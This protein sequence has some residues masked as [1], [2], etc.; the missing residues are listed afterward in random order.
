MA[1]VGLALMLLVGAGLLGRSF[2]QLAT[3]DIG[4]DIDQ[5]LEVRVAARGARYQEPATLIDFSNRLVDRLEQLPGVEAAGI[6]GP[7]LP[8]S[9]NKSGMHFRRDDLPNP[10]VGEEPTADIRLVAGDYFEAAGIELQQGRYLSPSDA[11]VE[12][13]RVVVNEALARRYFGG[14][15]PVGKRITFEWYDTLRAEIVGVVGNV[16][17]MGPAAAPSP[18]IYIPFG[19][20][21]DDLFHVMVRTAGE[22]GAVIGG[23][24]AAA[25]SVDPNQPFTVRP[26]TDVA[27]E[28][29]ARPTLNL[30]L[31]G[32]FSAIAMVLAAI[33]LY[34]V[35]SYTVRQRRQ[36]IGVRVALGAERWDVVRLVLGQG[37]RLTAL[38]ILLGLIGSV[39][40]TRLM[41]SMLFG[42]E[43]MDELTLL[44]V[45]LFLGT[46]AVLASYLPARRATRV[47]PVDALMP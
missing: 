30:I 34:G 31:L 17:E 21:P 8:L 25:S 2:H 27:R 43:P 6:I 16:R 4:L 3:V 12:Q 10:A 9:G 46:V 18:A 32:S 38:G 26:M 24:M 1:E 40:G 23:L 35:I 37:M 41:T 11:D 33:G 13:D 5:L 47:N 42:V 29:V 39:L 20:R 44:G 22:P 36:E 28:V 15:D 19:R 45:T 14:E 7:W